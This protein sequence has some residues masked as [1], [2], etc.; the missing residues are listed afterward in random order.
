M[1]K[2]IS[3]NEKRGPVPH[4]ILSDR[5]VHLEQCRITSENSNLMHGMPAF[6]FMDNSGKSVSVLIGQ[7]CPVCKKRVRGLNH[8]NGDHHKGIPTKRGR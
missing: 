7:Q 1:A 2:T 3:K 8:E 4:K 6:S 5:G